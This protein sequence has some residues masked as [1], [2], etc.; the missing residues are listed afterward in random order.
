[1]VFR[2]RVMC[3]TL[4]EHQVQHV[5]PKIVQCPHVHRYNRARRCNV[6]LI[7][8]LK[9]RRWAHDCREATPTHDGDGLTPR[10]CLRVAGRKSRRVGIPLR[11]FLC[12]DKEGGEARG[13]GCGSWG[14]GH[15]SAPNFP[16]CTFAPLDREGALRQRHVLD[17]GAGFPH[18]DVFMESIAP[19]M[20]ASNN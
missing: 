16:S 6:K 12:L 10:P 15:K 9:R 5:G 1:M 14:A 2:S 18:A 4:R 8:R 3:R 7:D 20:C 19:T 13:R 17:F 11:L